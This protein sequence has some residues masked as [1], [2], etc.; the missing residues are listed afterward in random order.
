MDITLIEIHL[1]F[2]NVCSVVLVTFLLKGAINK[3]EKITSVL[4]DN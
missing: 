3:M 1:N 2:E 4:T